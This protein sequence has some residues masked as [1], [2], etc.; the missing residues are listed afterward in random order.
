[1]PHSASTLD[2]LFQCLQDL[3]LATS[4]NHLDCPRFPSMGQRSVVRNV[5]GQTRWVTD[6]VT[7][8][9]QNGRAERVVFDSKTLPQEPADGAR[10]RLALAGPR[11]QPLHPDVRQEARSEPG[12]AATA[13]NA[14]RAAVRHPARGYGRCAASL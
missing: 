9:A 14:G 4:S 5:P 12:Y 2:D 13:S 1:M 8:E 6:G 11:M 3:I 7:R 10:G